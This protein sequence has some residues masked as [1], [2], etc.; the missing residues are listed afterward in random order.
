[1]RTNATE[2]LGDVDDALSLG[3][4]H[5]TAGLGP[6]LLRSAESSPPPV[7]CDTQGRTAA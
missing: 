4:E 5:A 2:R 1:M 3:S 7:A 6:D